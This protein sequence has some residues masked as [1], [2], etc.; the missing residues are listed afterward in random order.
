MHGVKSI[1]HSTQTAPWCSLF[2]TH[3]DSFTLRT[4]TYFHLSSERKYWL[5]WT[6]SHATHKAQQNYVQIS[7]IKFHSNQKITVESVDR[8]SFM[9]WV[10]Y[11]F[12]CANFHNTCTNSKNI[13]DMSHTKLY[14]IWMKNAENT[15]KISYLPR[16]KA[17]LSRQQCL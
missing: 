13:V 4:C 8:N 2:S 11:A 1:Q 16:S 3:R 14:F 17:W 12:H 5:P 9:P 6:N 15:G 7:Y 10:K